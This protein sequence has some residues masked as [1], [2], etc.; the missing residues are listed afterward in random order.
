MNIKEIN[1]AYTKLSH[2]IVLDQSLTYA[3]VYLTPKVFCPFEYRMH[4]SKIC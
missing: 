4:K 2:I 1:K 3:R